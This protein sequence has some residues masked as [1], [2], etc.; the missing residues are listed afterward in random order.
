MRYILDEQ[1][2]FVLRQA[3]QRHTLLF[4]G[5][6][7][8]GLTPTQWAA[9]A[10]LWEC[11]AQSQNH[12]GRRTAM[13]GAT[14]KGVIARL[15]LRGL[16]AIRPDPEDARRLLIELTEEGAGVCRRAAP[17]AL[18]IT[19]KTLSPLAEAEREILI[20]LLRKIV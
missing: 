17:V 6:M 4:A 1:V 3:Q 20:G 15:A 19:E 2:G 7:I 10:K 13:D 18:E 14:I 8:D 16:T 5:L 9:L 12:L 11:G